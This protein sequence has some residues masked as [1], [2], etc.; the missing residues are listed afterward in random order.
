MGYFMSKNPWLL[1]IKKIHYPFSDAYA[2][3]AQAMSGNGCSYVSGRRAPA[4]LGTPVVNC[5]PLPAA[6][7]PLQVLDIR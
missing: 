2:P 6:T 4:K 3:C 7:P 5:V 1:Y